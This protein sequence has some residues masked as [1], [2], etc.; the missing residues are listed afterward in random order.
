M[1]ITMVTAL[2]AVNIGNT[3][4]ARGSVELYTKGASMIG[5]GRTYL[6]MLGSFSSSEILTRSFF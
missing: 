2:R 4:F 5:S 3:Y 1:I 6:E